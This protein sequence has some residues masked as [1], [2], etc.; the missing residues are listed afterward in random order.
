MTIATTSRLALPF[1]AQGS[2]HPVLFISG[3]GDDRNGW[4][5]QVPA[6]ATN[7]RCITFDNRDVGASPRT[8][9][10]Y[11]IDDMARDA[12]TVLDRTGVERAHVVGHS[13]GGLISL[14]VAKLAPERVTGL[15]LVD[16]FAYGNA[17]LRA[18]GESWLLAAEHLSSE[19]LV[20]VALPYWVGES[21]IEAVGFENLVAEITP[22]IAAQGADAFRRQVT[23]TLGA[24]L[25]PALGA[26]TAPTL[27]V[28]SSEDT[29]TQESLSREL[30]LSIPGARLV[31]IEG[32]GHSPTVEQPDALNDALRE[33]FISIA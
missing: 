18:V 7:F 20:R 17:Y 1:E 19:Q 14:A 5:M 23:A 3:T 10:D 4:A 32:S 6:L 9:E 2:G 16:T 28:W 8:P 31:R 22:A 11:T 12:L 33:F 29:L 27:V 26:I 13:M 30:V 24:D 25:R 21:T 15:A